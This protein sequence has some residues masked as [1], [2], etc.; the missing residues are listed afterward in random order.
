VIAG[1]VVTRMRG[2]VGGITARADTLQAIYTFS[3]P[4][5]DTT[6]VCQ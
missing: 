5:R 4:L 2:T 1:R 6:N 3:A